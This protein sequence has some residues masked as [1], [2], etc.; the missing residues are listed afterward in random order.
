M[1]SYHGNKIPFDPNIIVI[2]TKYWYS[3]PSDFKTEKGLN[4]MHEH[5]AKEMLTHLKQVLIPFWEKLADYDN[6]G[7]YGYMGTD[8]IVDKKAEKGCILNSRILWFFSNAYLLLREEASDQEAYE[9]VMGCRLRRLAAHAYRFLTEACLDQEEGG[10]YWSIEACGQSLDETKHTYNQAFALYAL[11]SYY[12]AFGEREALALAGEIFLLIETKCRD[13]Y[14]Y[15]EAQSRDFHPIQNDKLSENGIIADRTM[16]TYLHI[17]EAYT[18]YVRVTGDKV[19]AALL[20]DILDT[21]YA[22]IYNPALGRLEVFFDRDMTSLLDL[23]SYGHDI[24]ASWL[25]DRAVEVA[26]SETY[27]QKMAPITAALSRNIYDTAYKESSLAN[28]C[29]KGVVDESRIWWVQAEAVVGFYNAW[30]TEPG[31][32]YY[33]EA[34]VTIWNFI[35]EH[36]VDHREGGE[37]FWRTDARGN[38]DWEAPIVEPWKCPYHN[39]RMCIEIIRRSRS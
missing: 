27:R 7:F 3:N 29:E 9:R 16:N 15:I 32:A 19:A 2:D 5:I 18:E 26:K 8:L 14:G 38:P 21:V 31:K 35:R 13:A 30:Q 12:D 33:L 22:Q 37:W 23:H 28:E 4:I 6:G 34:A 20:G 39:G 1:R 24:E 36:L 17:M 10:I 11:S 25:I